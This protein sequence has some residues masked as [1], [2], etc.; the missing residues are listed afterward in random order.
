MH[1]RPVQTHGERPVTSFI[2]G[3]HDTLAIQFVER[4]GVIVGGDVLAGE[5]VPLRGVMEGMGLVAAVLV[6]AQHADKVAVERVQEFILQD[7]S[8]D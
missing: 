3:D 5:Q 7:L 4:G 8:S 1:D 6:N 2:G